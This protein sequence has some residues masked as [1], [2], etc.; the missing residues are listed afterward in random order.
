[1]VQNSVG[2]G[3]IKKYQT[4]RIVECLPDSIGPN[5]IRSSKTPSLKSNTVIQNINSVQNTVINS[6]SRLLAHCWTKSLKDF[7]KGS[8][9]HMH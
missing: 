2:Q 4:V 5:R 3:N 6:L 8:I 7:C 1:M 9:T